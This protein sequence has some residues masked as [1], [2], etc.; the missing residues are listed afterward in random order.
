MALAVATGIATLGMATAGPASAG[1]TGAVPGA[2]SWDWQHCTQVLADLR[3]APPHGTPLVV[4]LGDATR[5]LRAVLLGDDGIFVLIGNHF[6]WF[7]D[8]LQHIAPAETA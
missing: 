4:L 2:T 6:R 7:Q 5:D 8:G 1:T 3:A